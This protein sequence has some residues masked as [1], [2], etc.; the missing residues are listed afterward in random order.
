MHLQDGLQERRYM[1]RQD[2]LQMPR[3]QMRMQAALR[4]QKGRLLL[5]EARC[6]HRGRESLLRN[7]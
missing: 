3:W 1:R 2:A 5:Q 6:D 7:V 4:M